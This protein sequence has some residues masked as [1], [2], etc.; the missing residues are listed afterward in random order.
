MG[1]TY[2][3]ITPWGSVGTHKL[4]KHM[5]RSFATTACVTFALFFF[6]GDVKG[7]AEVSALPV[8]LTVVVWTIVLL[9]SAISFFAREGKISRQV[10][11]MVGLF[12]AIGL[13]ATW[14]EWTPYAVDKTI[15]LFCLAFVAAVLPAFIIKNIRD[16]N[17]FISALIVSGLL[18]SAGGFWQV[19]EGASSG[20]PISG[21]NSNTI[22]L[23]RNAGIALVGLYS[24]VVYGEKRRMWLAIF[25][26]PLTL[27]LIGSGSRGPALFAAGVVAA[28]TL[29]WSLKSL[30]TTVTAFV[31]LGL[32]ASLLFLN[33]S[34]LPQGSVKR[35]EGFI[36]QQFDSSA[37][38]R[39]LAGQAALGGIQENPE[40]L[41]IGGFARIYNFGSVTDRIY[42]HNV[43]LE[44]TVEHGWFTGLLFVS[45]ICIGIKRAY[46]SANKD[47][48]LR[49][50]FA[51]LLFAVLN[52]LVSGDLTDNKIIYALMTIALIAPGFL[53]LRRDEDMDASSQ[54]ALAA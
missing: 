15:R 18:I 47:S 49:P 38:E 48:S 36:Q 27:V 6:A 26:L 14:T 35:L 54:F 19:L 2:T 33:S 24:L 10:L 23:G 1:P 46:I 32:T 13:T 31:F 7:N 34:S 43:I 52:S 40:G 22:S 39:F 17:I 45:I 16:V 3:G 4:N 20:G 28:V 12:A 25:F 21:I 42:P 11:W 41:G 37:E 5:T 9:L 53:N 30:Q 44:V 8:D 50:F 51:I 29:R